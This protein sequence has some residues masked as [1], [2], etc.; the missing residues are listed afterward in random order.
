MGEERFMVEWLRADDSVW[1]DMLGYSQPNH[2]LA[3]LGGPLAR[4]T[5]QRFA[6]DAKQAM[7]QAVGGR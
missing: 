4:R 7:V 2:R 1:F 5:Q 3:R 6:A